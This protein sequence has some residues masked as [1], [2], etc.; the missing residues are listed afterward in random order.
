MAKA[1]PLSMM[2]NKNP[3]LTKT[4]LRTTLLNACFIILLYVILSLIFLLILNKE[5]ARVIDNHLKHEVEHYM[6]VMHMEGDS[7]V[8]D[9]TRELAETDLVTISPTSFFLQVYTP[10]LEILYQSVNLSEF[11]DIPI[12]FPDDLKSIRLSNLKASAHSLRVIYA[13]LETEDGNLGAIMQLAA[14][15]TS[16]IELMPNLVLF[17]VISFPLIIILIIAGS[18]ILSKRS[19][20]P[21]NKIIDL[22]NSISL[23]H[24]N[25]RLNYKAD[26]NDELGRLR[27]TLNHLF[28]RLQ[29]QVGQISQ[30]TDNASHQLMSPLTV[31]KSE[32][33]YI[34]RRNHEHSE[35]RLGFSVM[36]EQTD[37]M[38]KIVRS[39]LILAKDCDACNRDGSFFNISKLISKFNDTGKYI[40]LLFDVENGLYVRGNEEYFTMVIENLIDN[41]FKYSEDDQPVKISAQ[42]SNQNIIVKVCDQGFGIPEDQRTKIF[43]RFYRYEQSEQSTIPGFGLGL[44]LV[45]AIVTTMGGSIEVKNNQPR[46][47]CFVITLPAL[48]LE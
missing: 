20:A 29:Q 24:L 13:P 11:S 35:C 28:D 18:I 26:P 42:R 12:I 31:L 32:L 25:Q 10:G 14:F 39:L 33:E 21:I 40:H 8:I 36:A 9:N 34:L 16:I 46:G 6:M 4:V 30:F 41:A 27:D 5:T 19:F 17:T 2:N 44:S 1:I 38:I 22:A 43:D 48:A 7:L 23:N 37:R 47:S 3:F 45:H 15:K